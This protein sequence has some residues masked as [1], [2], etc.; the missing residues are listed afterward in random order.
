MQTTALTSLAVVALILTVTGCSTPQPMPT[1]ELTVV[2]QE[3]EDFVRAPKGIG[4]VVTMKDAASGGKALYGSALVQKANPTVHKVCLPYDIVDAQVIFRY[5]RLHWRKTMKPAVMQVALKARSAPEPLVREVTFDNTGGWGY[6]PGDWAIVS[7]KL[8]YL[9]AGQY[10]VAIT[11]VGK[12]GDITIDGFFIA[13]GTFRVTAVEFSELALLKIGSGGYCGLRH[14]STTLRQDDESGVEVAVRAFLG[15]ADGVTAALCTPAGKE[16][17]DALTAGEAAT[18]G[19]NGVVLQTFQPA[20]G[21]LDGEYELLVKCATPDCGRRAQVVFVGELLSRFDE[22]LA[23]LEAFNAEVQKSN[24]AGALRCK[25]DAEHIVAWLKAQGERLKKST[26]P[27]ASA[28]KQGLAAAEGITNAAPLVDSVRKALEQAEE[29][30]RRVSMSREP[31]EG[32][33]GDLRRAFRSEATG[34]LKVYREYIP[35]CYATAEKVPLILMLHGGGG[36]ENYFPEKAHGAILKGL[37][38]RGYAALMPAYSSRDQKVWQDMGQLIELTLKEFP[39]LDHTRVYCTGISMGGFSTARMAGVYPD[40]FTAICCVSGSGRG[41][42][43]G[44]LKGIPTLLIA[45]GRDNVVPAS[46]AEQAAETL[47]SLGSTVLLRIFP[48]NGH[49][50]EAEP[51]LKL[52]LDWF[53]FH[54]TRE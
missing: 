9:D 46:M 19:E 41:A 22:R 52:T 30:M 47:E 37:E 10:Q 45:G 49:E 32:R 28:F 42:Q 48:T 23:K 24:E 35:T 5:A 40:L 54:K 14:H 50:Y 12:E 16:V 2:W 8:G 3:G 18:P 26:V 20:K 43:I 7:A 17:A 33:Y 29:T 27:A 15:Q 36:S 6:K 1:P 44:R 21:L 53:D 38:E 11:P 51:Y 34:E 4:D 25:A 39:K 13:S 31:Y